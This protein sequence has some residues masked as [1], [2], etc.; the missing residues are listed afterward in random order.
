MILEVTAQVDSSGENSKILQLL[1]N[2]TVLDSDVVT[3]T[4]MFFGNGTDG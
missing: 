2:P 3:L 1:Q 4:Q